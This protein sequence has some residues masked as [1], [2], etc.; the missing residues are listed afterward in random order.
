MIHKFSH[1]TVSTTRDAAGGQVKT[2]TLSKANIPCCVLENYSKLYDQYL[3]ND[4]EEAATLHF[5]DAKVFEAVTMNDRISFNGSNYR[6]YG[7]HDVL[8]AGQYFRLE[9]RR[10]IK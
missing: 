9:L 3:Q 4:E 7:K 6:V 1:Y 2:Y 5:L 10:E 8:Y